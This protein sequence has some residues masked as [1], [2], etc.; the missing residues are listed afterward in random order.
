MEKAAAFIL[1]CTVNN[2]Q[3]QVGFYFRCFCCPVTKPLTGPSKR[4]Y[5]SPTCQHFVVFT[6][7]DYPTSAMIASRTVRWTLTSNVP[8][9][10][11]YWRNIHGLEIGMLSTDAG[12]YHSIRIWL[13]PQNSVS[14]THCSAYWKAGSRCF[15]KKTQVIS[16]TQFK[17]LKNKGHNIDE[18]IKICAVL[19]VIYWISIA[20][21]TKRPPLQSSFHLQT[22]ALYVKAT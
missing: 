19:Y 10:T 17:Y 9:N 22:N 15:N 3:R 2:L 5:R 16:G 11:E 4:L 12:V 21:H 6:C 8:F 13:F 18:V 7:Y 20:E 14:P 1:S